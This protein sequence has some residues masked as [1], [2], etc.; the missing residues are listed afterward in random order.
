MQPKQ[1]QKQK[2]KPCSGVLGAL[3]ARKLNAKRPEEPAGSERGRESAG[4]QLCDVEEIGTIA[5][6]ELLASSSSFEPKMYER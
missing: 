5:S 4:L 3:Y 2:Q 1:F 6:L